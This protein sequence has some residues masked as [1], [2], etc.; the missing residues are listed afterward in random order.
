MPDRCLKY[1]V[2]LVGVNMAVPSYLEYAIDLPGVE[3]QQDE[4]PQILGE[5]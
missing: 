3:M 5:S 1:L 4:T 2:G